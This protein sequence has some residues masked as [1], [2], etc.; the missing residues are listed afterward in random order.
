M[1]GI[2]FVIDSSDESRV[3]ECTETFNYLMSEEKLSKVPILVFA[4]KQDLEFSLKPDEVNLKFFI[5][6]Y[7]SHGFE[8]FKK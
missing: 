4:N 8:L 2:V 1:D 6:D 7:W 5:L 3:K